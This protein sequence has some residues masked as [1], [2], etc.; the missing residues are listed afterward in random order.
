MFVP[1]LEC[2]SEDYLESLETSEAFANHDQTAKEEHDKA[3]MIVHFTPP[4]VLNTD[5]YK[6]WMK[7][8]PKTTKHLL[9]NEDNDHNSSETIYKM[10]YQLGLMS[11]DV[12]PPLGEKG[13]IIDKP[14]P[15]IIIF[16]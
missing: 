16:T 12:F 2:P 14:N 7:R 3:H 10:Q 1:V 5:R 15:V 8:F 9:V 11:S 13:C 6:A 4:S